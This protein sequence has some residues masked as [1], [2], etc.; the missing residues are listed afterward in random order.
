MSG[1]NQDGIERIRSEEND[2]DTVRATYSI[3]T[4]PTD[5]TLQILVEKLRQK[6]IVVPTFQRK[7]V[8]TPKQASRLIES[9]LLGL[10]VPPIYLYQEPETPSLLV[11]DGQQRLKSIEFFFAGYFDDNKFGK[12]H[13]FQLSDLSEKSP[14]LGKTYEA[15][16]NEDPIALARLNDAVLRAF[17]IKQVQPDDNTS[18]FHIFERLNTGGTLLKGQE[19]RNCVYHGKFNDML[20]SL[21]TDPIWRDIFGSGKPQKQ[22]RDVELILRFF[23]LHYARERYDKPMKDFLSDFMK[24]KQNPTEE[25]LEE[26]KELFIDTISQIRDSLGAK[27][28]HIR[29]GLNVA[30]FDSV[31][32]AFAE[33][34]NKIPQDIK[35][36]YGL[37]RDDPEFAKYTQSGTTAKDT[38][39]KR[40]RKAIEVLFG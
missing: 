1:K 3:L 19:I 8:W 28:F 9:F 11:L 40:I 7:F 38:V 4:Y 24:S 31:A 36:K 14:Y 17:V 16:Q 12:P 21:N 33:N 39:T 22:Q 2:R 26:Y 20:L 6:K 10:P 23:A 30:A 5:F 25:L 15:L 32:V 27:P 37:L 29:A 18:I 35:D 34:L 13:T